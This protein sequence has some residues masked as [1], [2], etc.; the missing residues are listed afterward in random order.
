MKPEDPQF[1]GDKLDMSKTTDRGELYKVMATTFGI[2]EHYL[3]FK[4]AG[5]PYG[6]E[7][8][9]TPFQIH[10][11]SNTDNP[12]DI[13]RIEP[14]KE[15]DKNLLLPIGKSSPLE[16][17]KPAWEISISEGKITGP[18]KYVPLEYSG[19]AREN[20][21]EHIPQIDVVCEYNLYDYAK[22]LY[23]IQSSDDLLIDIV[24][25]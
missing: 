7:G 14:T 1:S 22:Q 25:D 10:M 12:P 20:T 3:T 15:K 6:I 9:N 13:M 21:N 5:K 8:D 23:L 18:V 16:E 24:E 11:D 17:S 4:D 19:S 2:I